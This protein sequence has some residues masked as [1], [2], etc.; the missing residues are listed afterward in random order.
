MTHGTNMGNSAISQCFCRLWFLQA[1]LWTTK[2]WPYHWQSTG[3]GDYK[4]S[5]L[6][7]YVIYYTTYARFLTTLVG[8]VTLQRRIGVC[9]GLTFV[10]GSYLCPKYFD[11][12]RK[13]LPTDL[14]K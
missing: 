6:V 1:W 4:R 13:K 2:N 8:Y 3:T 7:S 14:T 12:A 5:G 9:H 11:S 10:R